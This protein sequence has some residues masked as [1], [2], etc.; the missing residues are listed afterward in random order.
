MNYAVLKN[1]Y[2]VAYPDLYNFELNLIN[3]M[4]NK[5]IQDS[6]YVIVGTNIKNLNEI[7][8]SSFF[9]SDENN[10]S[11]TKVFKRKNITNNK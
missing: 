5:K 1:Y 6:D 7:D 10:I 4:S 9:L 2:T 3:E 11:L 8:H